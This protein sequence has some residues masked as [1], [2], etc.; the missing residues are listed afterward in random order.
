MKNGKSYSANMTSS[1]VKESFVK[2]HDSSVSES[3]LSPSKFNSAPPRKRKRVPISCLNCKKRKVKCDKNRPCSGCVK[4]QVAHLCQYLEPAWADSSGSDNN[5]VVNFHASV[6]NSE[7][8]KTLKNATDKTISNQR[9]EIED[10]KRQLSVFHE[11]SPKTMVEIDIPIGMLASP[12]TVLKKLRAQSNEPEEEIQVLGDK[13]YSFENYGKRTNFNECINVFSWFNVIKL[14]PQLTKFW[15]RITNLQ[16]IYHMYKFNQIKQNKSR[17]NIKSPSNNPASPK[18]SNYR[19]NE[20]D[21]TSMF[22]RSNSSFNNGNTDPTQS[23]CPV[24]ECDFNFM[25]EDSFATPRSNTPSIPDP[26]PKPSVKMENDHRLVYYGMMSDNA[27]DL[28]GRM[29]RVWKSMLYLVRGNLPLNYNQIV[30]LVDF[31]FKSD[32]IDLENKNHFSFYK[33]ELLEVFRKG[34]DGLI[35]DCSVYRDNESDEECLGLLKMKGVYLSILSLLVEESL[36]YLRLTIYT[37]SGNHYVDRFKDI[38]PSEVFYQ[39]LGYKENNLLPLVHDLLN[40]IHTSTSKS[41]KLNQSLP[42]VALCVA[43]ANR[44][45]VLFRRPGTTSLNVRSSFTSICQILLSLI[46]GENDISLPI[47][48]DPSIFNFEGS[49]SRKKDL[50]IHICYVWCDILRLTNLFAFE[51]IVPLKRSSEL[52]NLSK[53]VFNIIQDSE[54]GYDHI[55]YLAR[56]KEDYSCLKIS[57][58]VHYLIRRCFTI[59]NCSIL[60]TGDFKITLSTIQ[61][62]INDTNNWGN[63]TGVSK[64]KYLRFFELKSILQY[65]EIFLSYL[66]ILQSEE[67]SNDELIENIVPG[68]FDKCIDS[69]TLFQKFATYQTQSMA[70]QYILLSCVEIVSRLTQLIIGLLMRFKVSEKNDSKM[71]YSSESKFPIEIDYNLKEKLISATDSTLQVLMD[72]PLTEKKKISKLFKY[73]STFLMFVGHPLK[74]RSL[75]YAK[76]HANIPGFD[77]ILS[78]SIDKCPVVSNEN[79]QPPQQKPTPTLSKCPISHITDPIDSNVHDNAVIDKNQTKL[80]ARCPIDH[81]SLDSDFSMASQKGKCPIDHAALTKSMESEPS[82]SNSSQNL[83]KCPFDH[84]ALRK[85]L[86]GFNESHIRG[87][88]DLANNQTNKPPLKLGT[89]STKSSSSELS[90]PNKKAPVLVPTPSSTASIPTINSPKIPGVASTQLSTFEPSLIS[91]SEQTPLPASAPKFKPN[92]TISLSQPLSSQSPFPVGDLGNNV[93]DFPDFDFDFLQNEHWFEQLGNDLE[94]SSL[95]GFFQ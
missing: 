31:Y 91:S 18:R 34:N 72:S 93:T 70:L 16:K 45:H 26:K 67:Q 35:F 43:F 6:Q 7:E 54:T 46:T 84:E 60:E 62:V 56:L 94:N 50:K 87:S 48:K 71:V 21:F 19:I 2:P 11:F 81:T 29:Q 75:N 52:S 88:A 30:F 77:S 69:L 44:Q 24:I 59:L 66:C 86:K 51:P 41:K 74:M 28:M 85:G 68:I 61:Q 53:K 36:D 64:L 5:G 39:G 83:Q 38:F 79:S 9:K 40:T 32:I 42:F 76:L 92:P 78:K 47:F 23:K 65:L 82:L 55:R 17:M 90:H 95:E 33:K 73:W 80:P 13:Y 1:S 22:S 63:S 12:L 4:N 15:Y 27:K 58:H 49:E 10:L 57:F 25:I 3:I 14:D 37:D 8:Y 89:K 20:I